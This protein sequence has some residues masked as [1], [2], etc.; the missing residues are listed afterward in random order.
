MKYLTFF[1]AKK[2]SIVRSLANEFED[3]KQ[4]RLHED[5]FSKDD[6][7]DFADILESQ[8]KAHISHELSVLINMSALAINELLE[9]AQEQGAHVTLDTTSLENQGL[10]DSIEKMSVDM[11]PAA[12]KRNVGLVSLKDEAKA[13]QN[14]SKAVR[15]EAE[16]LEESNRMLHQRF[17][18]VQNDASML[19]REKTALQNEV[20]DL[21]RRLAAAE[22]GNESNAK[23]GADGFLQERIERLEEEL[24]LE[25]ESNQKRV[26]DTPQFQQMRKMM[27]SQNQKIR[28]LRRRLDRYEPDNTK[29][30]DDDF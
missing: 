10:I 6:M 22:R 19:L 9:T 17:S 3:S 12:R 4:D 30:D 23:G 2:E 11:M 25:R 24:S 28:D 7:I 16:R 20:A 15:E 29:E 14:E 18:N 8:T 21:K 5:V 27:Q 1:R 13:L 26:A